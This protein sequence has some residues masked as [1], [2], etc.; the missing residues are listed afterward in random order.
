M[1]F[2]NGSSVV[3]NG[4]NSVVSGIGGSP[5]T[6]AVTPSVTKSGI[7]VKSN[8]DPVVNKVGASVGNVITVDKSISG[9]PVEKSPKPISSVVKPPNGTFVVSK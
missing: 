5:V 9:A 1:S 3:P 2:M 8:I 4:T 6:G 7:V